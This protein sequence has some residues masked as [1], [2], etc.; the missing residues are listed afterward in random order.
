MVVLLLMIQ[1]LDDLIHTRLPQFLKCWH[2]RSCRICII[3]R[4]NNR[5]GT[6]IAPVVVSVKCNSCSSE[7]RSN[8]NNNN[9]N[10]GCSGKHK[11]NRAGAEMVFSSLAVLDSAA[12]LPCTQ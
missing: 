11:S 3:N 5:A 8:H 2:I 9:H 1:F 6:V 7:S 12:M 4:S 10:I